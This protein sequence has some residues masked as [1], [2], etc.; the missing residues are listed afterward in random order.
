MV[1]DNSDYLTHEIYFT[2]AEKVTVLNCTG[3]ELTDQRSFVSRVQLFDYL[4]DVDYFIKAVEAL[5]GH[6]G[7]E[8]NKIEKGE[9][10]AE[11]ENEEGGKAEEVKESNY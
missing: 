2:N 9:I 8:I 4:K 6:R 10:Q 5:E 1:V 11:G 7:A 3:E